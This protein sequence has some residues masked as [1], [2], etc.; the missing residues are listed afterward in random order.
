M[1][2]ILT[3]L[4]ILFSLN[5]SADYTVGLSAYNNGDTRTAIFEWLTDMKDGE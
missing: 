4:I 3:F 5:S 1:K 2:K